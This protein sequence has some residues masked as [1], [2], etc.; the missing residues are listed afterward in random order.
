MNG[1]LLPGFHAFT[2]PFR[3]LLARLLEA[4][5]AVVSCRPGRIAK[6]CFCLVPPANALPSCGPSSWRTKARTDRTGES[7]DSSPA[8]DI[9]VGP[10]TQRSET[11]QQTRRQRQG[12]SSGKA[13]ERTV[14][15]LP[16][17][18]QFGPS[19]CWRGNLTSPSGWSMRERFVFF[20]VDSPPCSRVR[21]RFGNLSIV[22]PNIDLSLETGFGRISSSPSRPPS[23]TLFPW[24]DLRLTVG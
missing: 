24:S 20:C 13:T 10:R 4:R 12:P 5:E 2:E 3:A 16:E 1:F 18:I 11:L 8:N 6:V 9:P 14:T 17:Q 21:L 23:P 7:S 15:S 22:V 19:C